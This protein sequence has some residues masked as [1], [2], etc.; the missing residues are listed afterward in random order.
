MGQ[1]DLFK[2]YLYEI[3]NSISYNCVQTNDYK[4]TKG[5]LEKQQWDMKNIVMIVIKHLQMN[6]VLTLNNL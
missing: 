5:N 3:A 6:S 2:N 4:Q 1:I